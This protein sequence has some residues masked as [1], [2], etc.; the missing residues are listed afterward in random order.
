MADSSLFGRYVNIHACTFHLSFSINVML[1]R[2][3][4]DKCCHFESVNL[5]FL[6]GDNIN[7]LSYIS[8]K[9]RIKSLY[10]E[11]TE[12]DSPDASD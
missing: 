9:H 2:M 1:L 8:I 5:F 4:W 10:Q 3:L 12:E 11:T 6:R 7:L